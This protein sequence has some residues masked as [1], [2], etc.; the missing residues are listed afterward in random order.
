MT[1]GKIIKNVI[2]LLPLSSAKVNAKRHHSSASFAQRAHVR[3][4]R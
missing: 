2:E 1:F 3:V 4:T